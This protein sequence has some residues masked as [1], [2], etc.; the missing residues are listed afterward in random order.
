MTIGQKN[1]AM[2]PVFEIQ[3]N[4]ALRTH[5]RTRKGLILLITPTLALLLISHPA[6][7]Q[8]RSILDPIHPLDGS[9]P[10]FKLSAPGF[11]SASDPGDPATF[12][13]P[14]DPNRAETQ[15]LVRRGVKRVLRDQRELYRAPFS[16]R[17]SNGTRSF[18]REPER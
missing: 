11:S 10:A 6:F 16:A 2:K 3:K 8:T 13:D 4:S 15:G 7:S 18:W 9:V 17:I 5:Q 1:R 12:D 14:S